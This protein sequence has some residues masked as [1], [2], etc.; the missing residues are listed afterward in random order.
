MHALG[1][2]LNVCQ[3]PPP[4]TA[5][6]VPP[7]SGATKVPEPVSLIFRPDGA[8]PLIADANASPPALRVGGVVLGFK[9]TMSQRTWSAC[10]R[11]R[12]EPIVSPD[13]TAKVTTVA[14][15]SHLAWVF[16]FFLLSLIGLLSF[17]ACSTHG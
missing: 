14:P 13:T 9:W 6:E 5:L 1:Q 3:V 15:K 10:P 4:V 11:T 16:I 17:Q 12:R 2:P 7:L 8:D